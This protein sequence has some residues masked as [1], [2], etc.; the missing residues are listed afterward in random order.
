MTGYEHLLLFG[1]VMV[2]A[3]LLFTYMWPRMMLYVYKRAILV[4]G[5][6]DGPI[7]VNTLYTEPQT[8]FADPLHPPASASWLM[9]TGV[10]RDT[11]PTVGWLDLSKGPQVL[12]VPDMAGR[13]Y[14]V[15]F[16]DPSNN[17]NFAYV[18]KRTTGTEAGDFLIT[19]PNWN[20]VVPQGMTQI[21][22]SNNS[23]LV[24]GRTLVESDSDLP[25]AYNLAKQ[26][27]LMPLS[28]RQPSP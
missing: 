6:G 9:T 16:T 21:S 15:Q 12:H 11:L 10:N 7:P 17:T 1:S 20:G 2:A 3:W 19:K 27:Q 8:L 24:L 13:Y 23:V 28:G 26:L 22:S 4:K 25:I 18:G 5:G 14:S